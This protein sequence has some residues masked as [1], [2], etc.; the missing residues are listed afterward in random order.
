VEKFKKKMGRDPITAYAAMNYDA[1]VLIAMAA[2]FAQS[3]D[4]KMIRDNLWKV[5]DWLR[6]QST[7]GDKRFDKDGMQGFGEYQK[8]IIK[9]GKPVKY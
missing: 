2:N 5:D 8:V 6:G 3:D 9:D 4:P 1:L 7:G